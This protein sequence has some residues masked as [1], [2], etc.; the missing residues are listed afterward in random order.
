MSAPLTSSSN[1]NKSNPTPA[2]HINKCHPNKPSSSSSVSSLSSTSSSTSSLHH[3]SHKDK[4][5]HSSV[6]LT[7]QPS[8]HPPPHDNPPPPLIL[9][10][11][12]KFNR[13]NRNSDTDRKKV[14]EIRGWLNDMYHSNNNNK[15]VIPPI[16]LNGESLR[17]LSTLKYLSS[18]RD[19]Q[20]S[21][22]RISQIYEQIKHYRILS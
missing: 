18:R 16:E 2:F 19:E 22:F 21:N 13:E 14:E 7:P 9:T 12:P 20:N 17:V 11:T 6:Y 1:F 15:R 4:R 10:E 5:P 3:H 8:L